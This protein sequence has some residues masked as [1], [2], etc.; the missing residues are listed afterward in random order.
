[1]LGLDGD[2]KLEYII[3]EA[4]FGMFCYFNKN[5]IFDFVSNIMANLASLEQ[6]REFM[7]K[8]KYIEVIVVQLI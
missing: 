7:I 3:V 5:T 1:M 4:I 2:K 8:N 6:G